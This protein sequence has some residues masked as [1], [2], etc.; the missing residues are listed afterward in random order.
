MQLRTS[1]SMRCA[2]SRLAWSRSVSE[3]HEASPQSGHPVVPPWSEAC[4]YPDTAG[5]SGSGQKIELGIRHPHQLSGVL[6]QA[7]SP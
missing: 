7:D 5:A 1:R 2:S 6:V 3:V 4:C